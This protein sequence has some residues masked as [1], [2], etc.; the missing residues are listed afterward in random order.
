MNGV[1]RLDELIKEKC[2]D[3]VEYVRL[4]ELIKKYSEKSKMDH[5]VKLVY[6]VSNKE[7]LIPSLEYWAKNTNTKRVDYQIYSDD[8]SN[9]NII[10]E[11][12]FAY[13]PARLNIGSIDCLFD[14]PAGLLSPM[15]VVFEIVD[16]RM[17]PDFLL[18]IFETS[19]VKKAINNFK[20]EGARFRFDFKNWNKIQIPIPPLK[21]QR[22]I[23]RILDNFTEL[24]AELTARKKQYEYYRDTLLDFNNTTSIIKNMLDKY[25]GVEYKELCEICIITSGGD[26]P[27]ENY[28]VTKTEN[29]TVPII[30]NGVGDKALCGYTDIPKITE[31]AVTVS[32]RGTIGY[33]EYR[34]YSYY[35]VVRLLSIIPH[36]K[37][38]LNCKYLYYC[39]QDKKYNV[40]ITGIPQ[41]TIPMIKNIL[42]PLPPLQVQEYIVNI[43]DRFDML[44]N[45]LTKGLP[46]EIEMRIK[47]Y[48]YYRDSLLNFKMMN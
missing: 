44:C 45:D 11:N 12:M 31:T 25:G 24:T 19:I 37:N 47:Q 36:D 15:Y 1:S 42:I 41:L 6:T 5:S 10:R 21:V 9:Y 16:K 23:V 13:N 30:S 3:G 22:E 46:A 20:E 17:R 32:A 35:P 14:K 26:I 7:G 2:P 48:E 18:K 39:L 28:S 38:K 4:G 34:D 43:L 27:K 33:A 40:P 8:T 29:F